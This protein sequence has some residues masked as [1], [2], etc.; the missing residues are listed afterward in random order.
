MPVWWFASGVMFGYV[1]M[2]GLVRRGMPRANRL[3][4]VA[5][6][7]AG[8]A[9]YILSDV[10]LG[11]DHFLN[12]WIIPPALLLVAYWATGE[13]FVAP[14]PRAERTLLS[15]DRLLEVER[16]AAAAPRWLA[17]LLELAYLLVYP[18]VPAAL[19]LALVYVPD[20]DPHRF[21]AVVLIT[22][23]ICFAGLQWVQ[24][25]PPRALDPRNPWRTSSAVRA[26]N[27]RLLGATSI[28]VNT[29]PSGHAAEAMAAAL[30]VTG[31]PAPV[32]IA[33]FALALAICAGA[34]LGRYHYAA[35]IFA[36]WIVA[37]VV[38]SLV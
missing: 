35:D 23:Y 29:F 20:T 30:L 36:G 17:E 25:R 9:I 21:W 33:M 28:H 19:V 12:R 7:A 34:V 13:F 10:A 26:L 16:A 22:D 8:L 14:M 6:S 32:T 31:A 3:R 37:V 4:C 1:G 24:T 5:F 11:A 38:W 27:L 15:I 18:V 2:G